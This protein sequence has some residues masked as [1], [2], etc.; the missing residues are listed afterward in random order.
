[1]SSYVREKV[2][3]VPVT[4]SDLSME[5]SNDLI[6]DLEEKYPTLFE[7]AQP[8][9][10]QIAP[11]EN[12]YLDY[13]LEYEWDANGEYG[14]VRELYQSEKERYKPIFQKILP[15]IN[16]DMVHLVEFCWYNCSEA[17]SYYS[18]D[19]NNDEFYEEV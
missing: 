17:P 6:Y 7:Y 10:F 3:R 12:L 13:I 8:R 9:C 1:M 14:K 4:L 16:M 19:K 11:T 5:N 15:N 18:M 2:L